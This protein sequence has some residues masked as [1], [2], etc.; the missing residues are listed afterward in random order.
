MQAALPALRRRGGGSIVNI[1]SIAGR[2]GFPGHGAYG[3]SKWGLLGLSQ[4]A[5]REF[6]RD[7]IRVNSVLPGPIETDMMPSDETSLANFRRLPL[8]RHGR[9]DEV[10]ELVCF[11]ASDASSYITG[12]EHVIDG[13]SLV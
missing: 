5:A 6:G 10:S 12:A 1:A 2:R 13:G 11:L 9:P 3:A 7:G 8:R 4:V